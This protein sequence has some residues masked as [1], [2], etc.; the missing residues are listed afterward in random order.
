[1]SETLDLFSPGPVRPVADVVVADAVISECGRYRYRLDRTWATGP[2]ICWV[3]LNP[4]TADADADDPTIRKIT[5]YSRRWGFGSL[6]VVNLWAWRSTDPKAL[7]FDKHDVV[8]PDANAYIREALDDSNAVVC[9]WGCSVH[10]RHRARRES[11]VLGMI[12]AARHVPKA[13]ALTADG[14]PTHPL[15]QRNDAELVEME[16]RP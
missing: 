4:S 7:P 13:L 2:R 6:V 3:M 9:G 10:K 8:G 16:V 1:M 12:R 15:Y 14:S 11:A 5:G